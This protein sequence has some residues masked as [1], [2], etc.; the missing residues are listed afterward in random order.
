MTNKT[1]IYHIEPDETGMKIVRD[2]ERIRDEYPDYLRD[3]SNTVGCDVEAL[4]FPR[5]VPN[6]VFAVREA[7][8]R[9][10]AITASGARTGIC[11][12]P[13]RRRRSSPGLPGSASRR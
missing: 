13:W 9:G 1:G 11:A 12:G 3:E 7:A 4:F 5:S 10:K 8:E 2:V 6:I